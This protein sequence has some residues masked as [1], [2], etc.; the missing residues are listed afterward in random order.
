MH[1]ARKTSAL[2]NLVAVL[3]VGISPGPT[4]SGAAGA[5]QTKEVFMHLSVWPCLKSKTIIII[6]THHTIDDVWTRN[7]F[8]LYSYP[9]GNHND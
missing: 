4:S 2:V 7:I 1:R 6:I 3:S 9:M 5:W 8:S